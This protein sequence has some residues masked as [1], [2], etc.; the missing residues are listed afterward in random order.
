MKFAHIRAANI[1]HL[2]R[3][4]FTAQ[5]F[6]LPAGQISLKKGASYEVPFFMD[7]EGLEPLTCALRTHR[8]P[9]RHEYAPPN[10]SPELLVSHNSFVDCFITS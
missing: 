4:Y 2:Q 10:I 8:S 5:L 3:K 9:N 6:H 1:S 7:L